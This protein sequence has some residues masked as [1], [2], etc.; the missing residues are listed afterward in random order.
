MV[1]RPIVWE[2]VL[3]GSLKDRWWLGLWFGH[4]EVSMVISVGAVFVGLFGAKEQSFEIFCAPLTF[5]TL[6]A[7]RRID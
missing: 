6:P 4:Y 1:H 7:R 2:K 5:Q 3:F